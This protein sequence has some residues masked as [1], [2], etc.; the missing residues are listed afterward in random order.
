VYIVLL[1]LLY[2]SV[3]RHCCTIFRP[4][5]VYHA[6]PHNVLGQVKVERTV[7][8]FSRRLAHSIFFLSCFVSAI[9]PVHYISHGVSHHR[10]ASVCTTGRREFPSDCQRSRRRWRRTDTSTVIGKLVAIGSSSTVDHR[11]FPAGSPKRRTATSRIPTTISHRPNAEQQG[12]RWQAAAASHGAK[13]V[14]VQCV[15]ICVNADNMM[16]GV[17]SPQSQ[18]WCFTSCHQAK[19]YTLRLPTESRKSLCSMRPL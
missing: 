8:S 7:Y 4:K 3:T 5:R 13:E 16:T 19:H 18:V 12:R 9:Y 10:P 14:S 15:S 1:F 11:A 17:E 6:S 2:G